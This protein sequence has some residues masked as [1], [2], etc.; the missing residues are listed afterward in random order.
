MSWSHLTPEQA[1]LAEKIYQSL[2]H[3]ADADLRGLAE[4]L[5]T[6][7]DR[8]LLG[9]AEFDVRDHV[10]NIGAKAFETA[11]DVRKKGATKAPA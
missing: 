5:A 7:P 4:L 3:A 9:Q 1:E 11:L 6:K 2:K 10:H 8:Q